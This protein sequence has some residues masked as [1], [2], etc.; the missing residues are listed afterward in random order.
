MAPIS[1]LWLKTLDTFPQILVRVWDASKLP[2]TLTA[3]MVEA[4]SR[5][6]L[7]WMSLRQSATTCVSHHFVREYYSAL[8][9]AVFKNGPFPTNLSF[10]DESAGLADAAVAH[11]SSLAAK[12]SGANA[13]SG[14][15]GGINNY[16]LQDRKNSG[17]SFTAK[18]PRLLAAAPCVQ[19]SPPV[20]PVMSAAAWTPDTSGGLSG[21][22][23]VDPGIVK[24]MAAASAA[25][26]AVYENPELVTAITKG[27]ATVAH[28]QLLATATIYSS[29]LNNEGGEPVVGGG[30]GRGGF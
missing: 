11:T 20:T 13:R 4:F 5:N 7:H 3:P 6:H 24:Q 30:G 15:I 12:L 10:P 23:F 21:M 9:A 14:G 27:D 28:N 17:I 8:N 26:S 25:L 2:S 1:G 22:K 29:L 19:R 18:P 16:F